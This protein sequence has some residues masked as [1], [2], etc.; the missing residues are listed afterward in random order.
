MFDV[1]NSGKSNKRK[2]DAKSKRKYT[3]LFYFSGEY[4]DRMNIFKVVP[5]LEAAGERREV[6]ERF[7]WKQKKHDS[8][9]GRNRSCW[10]VG[11]VGSATRLRRWW[12]W[13]CRSFF[14]PILPERGRTRL[15]NSIGRPRRRMF[16]SRN[17]GRTEVTKLAA[18]N[19]TLLQREIFSKAWLNQVVAT[20]GCVVFNR[21]KIQ[22][23]DVCV[24]S[25][26]SVIVVVLVCVGFRVRR[27]WPSPTLPPR[28]TTRWSARWSC[29]KPKPCSSATQATW[30]WRWMCSPVWP[31]SSIVSTNRPSSTRCCHSCGTSSSKIPKSFKKLSVSGT[32][33]VISTRTIDSSSFV[34]WFSGWQVFTSGWSATRR[35]DCRSA[36]WP[37]E[38]CHRSYRRPWILHSAWNS[39]PI[40][41][42]CFKRCSTTSTGASSHRSLSG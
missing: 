16:V 25:I 11:S 7:V 14:S 42:K 29:P 36:W 3:F 5:T 9:D 30:N 24:S 12:W 39:S 38:S 21:S 35:T 8:M 37:L 32:L 6:S 26:W 33:A 13:K 10:N 1:T 34:D 27:W 40:C 28:W 31:K 22:H 18:T 17:T 19:G 41:S 20:G 4:G 15:Q 2:N 23:F